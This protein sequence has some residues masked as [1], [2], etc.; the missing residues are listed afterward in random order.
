[1]LTY[2]RIDHEDHWP[3]I[4]WA[5][6]STFP[7]WFKAASHA[8]TKNLAEFEAFWGLCPEIYGLFDAAAPDDLLGCVYLEFPAYA[9]LNIHISVIEQVDDGELARFFRSLKELKAREGYRRM[10]GY[11]VQK[12]KRL[13]T[14]AGMAGFHPTG[15]TM[16]YGNY[17]GRSLS[18]LQVSA[19]G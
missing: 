5:K 4:I 14:V 10:I 11:I 8:W 2:R 9:T 18:W 19:S 13:R 6:E 7:A 12:N 17:K 15:L 1:M 3:A 16:L